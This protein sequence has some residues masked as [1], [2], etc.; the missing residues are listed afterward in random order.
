MAQSHIAELE[1]HS[2]GIKSLHLTLMS[3]KVYKVF[4]VTSNIL[5]EPGDEI[6][7]WHR[8]RC[9]KSEQAHDI[10]KNDFG[11]SHVPSYL[12][13]VNAAW[14]NIAV[15]AMN[16]NNML[17]KFFLPDGFQNCRMKMMRNIFYTLTGKIVHHARRITMKIYSQDIGAQ[18]L[19]YALSRL[20][21]VLQCVT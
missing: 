6:I 3:E 21:R 1:S 16:V 15:L 10:L 17:K 12:F 4:G 20:D 19:M 18:L 13:G 14:W 5:G 11:G 9:G 8:D 2:E 7:L